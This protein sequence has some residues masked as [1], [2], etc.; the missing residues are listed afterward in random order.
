[1]KSEK[2]NKAK[3]EALAK[4]ETKAEVKHHM[5]WFGS[6]TWESEK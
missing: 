1:V 5:E 6:Q 4:D 3:D 2:W